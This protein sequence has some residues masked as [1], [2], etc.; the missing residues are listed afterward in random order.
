MLFQAL[1]DNSA[2][3]FG[4]A[5]QAKV[6]IVD[7]NSELLSVL[8]VVLEKNGYRVFLAE[9]AGQAVEALMKDIPDV[10]VCDIMMPDKSGLELHKDI[11][12]HPEWCNIPF[13]FLTA[14]ASDTDIRTGKGTGADD[15]LTKPFDPDELLSVINGKLSAAKRRKAMAAKQWDGYCRRIIHTLSHEFRTPLVSINT[16]TELLIDQQKELNPE[17]I[18]RLLESIWRG[19]QRLER[20]VDD[21]M[22]LQ[23]IDLGH[24]Y[25]VCQLYRRNFY[26][27]QIVQTAVDCFTE[28]YAEQCSCPPVLQLPQEEELQ[29]LVVSVYDVQIVSIIHRLLHNAYKFA[30]ND[31]S[32]VVSIG[33]QG[34]RG[35]VCVRD[36]GPGLENFPV[37]SQ[38]ACQPFVQINRETY[39]QQGCGLGLTVC[40]YFTQLNGG[41]LTLRQPQDGNGLEAVID[42]PLVGQ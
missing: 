41:N 40:M 13:I 23:Q 4:G 31:K 20:L 18:R 5:Y 42:F 27:P 34:K 29:D 1:Q 38:I 6:L 37:S 32:A 33:I 39:E 19:G 16:G 11:Q 2:G 9:R 15:Y 14:L 7:D 22:L 24:A 12:E 36:Y 21:F 3:K 35:F 28:T 30:G 17:Q 8:R 26:L 25:N 10:I